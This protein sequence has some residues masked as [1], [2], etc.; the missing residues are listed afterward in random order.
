MLLLF[1]LLQMARFEKTLIKEEK[2]LGESN[3]TDL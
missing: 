3:N 1:E 2:V